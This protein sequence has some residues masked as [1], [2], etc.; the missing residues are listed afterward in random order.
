MTTFYETFKFAV[1][2]TFLLLTAC[3]Q[4]GFSRLENKCANC[5]EVELDSI[6]N[7]SCSTCH[8]G[9]PSTHILKD[10]H[11][12][13]VTMPAHP[14]KMT[15]ICG[16]CHQDE[17]AAALQSDHFTL[18]DEI[19]A[20]WAVFFPEN[21]PMSLKK[22][23]DYDTTEMASG[24]DV[25]A[26]AM[27]RRCLRCHPYYKG[28]EYKG[29][30]RGAGCAACH[31]GNAAG[32]AFHRFDLK[33][34]DDRCLS[35]H[36]ANFTG[37][38]YYGRFEKDY[39]E[40]FRAPLVHGNLP[41]R[42]FGVEWHE[43]KPDI[44][45]K[46]GMICTDCHNKRLCDKNNQGSKLQSVNCTSCHLPQ[47]NPLNNNLSYPVM[48]T[49]RTGHKKED[50]ARVAC[51]VCHSVWS[52]QDK[53]RFLLRQ[54]EPSWSDWMYLGVQGSSE[55]EGQIFYQ[56]VRQ[57][58]MAAEEVSDDTRELLL[59]KNTCEEHIGMT[60]KFSGKQQTGLWFEG[61]DERLWANPLV[62]PDKTG[63]LQIVRPVLDVTFVYQ[64]K[65]GKTITVKNTASGWR[66]Y[67]AHTVGKADV[68]RTAQVIL[69][70]EGRPLEE[71]G[72]SC[73]ESSANP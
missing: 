65:T 49:E 69:W 44:H 50:I 73:P 71:T 18:K 45:K 34:G 66:P 20:V 51:Q 5:H 63:K 27:K 24:E 43:M 2:I 57:G 4:Q 72:L 39:E 3:S 61:F 38:D 25:V 58:D 10:A 26:D 12:D 41:P 56:A 64:N 35:C 30:K 29:V 1:I 31:I 47:A 16:R 14:D 54:D 40:D 23:Q 28:D 70:L 6:H 15:E 17:V 9:N 11:Q 21:A 67:R 36:Y 53:G 52:V 13:L 62:C 68:F 32:K 48:N 46:A 60:D 55:V 42:P 37:Y 59:K 22:L 7:F 19:S 8:N 33:V